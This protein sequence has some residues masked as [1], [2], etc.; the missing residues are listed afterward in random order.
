MGLSAPFF[1]TTRTY[2][3]DG[4]QVPHKFRVGE[5]V[6]R[7]KGIPE[8]FEVLDVL[9]GGVRYRVEHKHGLLNVSEWIAEDD[10][11]PFGVFRQTNGF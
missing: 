6:Q 7:T 2:A 11:E 8:R 9:E 5:G 1:R 4:D 3:G 10:L